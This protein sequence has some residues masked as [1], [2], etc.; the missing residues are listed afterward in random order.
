M[1]GHTIII[2]SSSLPFV[3]EQKL[4]KLPRLCGVVGARIGCKCINVLAAYFLKTGKQLLQTGKM[5]NTLA[6]AC[7][8][9]AARV[10]KRH[11]S[12]QIIC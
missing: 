1:E 4:K 5:K 10:F 3:Y 11:I 6:P 2:C 12:T 9:V 8:R 7:N